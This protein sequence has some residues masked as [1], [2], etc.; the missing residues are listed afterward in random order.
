MTPFFICSLPR[1]RTAW[2]ANFLTYGPSYC[3][4]E[5]MHQV[6]LAQYPWL[7]GSV[8]TEFAGSSDS[9]NTLVMEQLIDMFPI[10]K[11][12]V[13]KRDIGRVKESLD[14]IGLP[15]T[16]G[17]LEKM[18]EA[19][20]RLIHVYR[21]LVIPYVDFDAAKIWFYLFPKVPL[22]RRRLEM[23]DSMRINVPAAISIQ[24]G[25]ELIHRNGE[26]LLPLLR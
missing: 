25:V 4:H 11:I 9:V 21:P 7:L 15:S 10:A 20:N 1:S 23:L 16:G 24:K 5:P 14:K 12:V 22:N 17:W 13:I 18:D 3:F 26:M 6:P 8:G 19:L 2:L